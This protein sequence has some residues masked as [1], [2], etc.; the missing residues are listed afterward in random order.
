MAPN[1]GPHRLNEI[2]T[3]WTA[4]L[5]AHGDSTSV[6][7]AA[8]RALVERYGAAVHHYLLGILKDAHAADELLQEFLLALI[9]GDFHKAAPQRGRFRDYVKTVLAHLVSHY[10]RQD[11]RQPAL[12]ADHP[13]WQELADA[14]AA[15]LSLESS[16][17]QELM[18]RTWEV[19]AE[20]HPTLYQ[21]LWLRAEHPKL[22]S[23]ELAQRLGAQQGRNFTGDAVRQLLRRARSMFSDVLLDEVT[24]SLDCPERADLE[25]ELADLNLLSYCADALQRRF[26]SS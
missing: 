23:H 1:P 21:V 11:A 15:E 16:L 14:E 7:N 3:L 25:R 20:Q 19:L 17:R 5:A 24:A 18:T 12:A 9:R 10:R 4:L 6:R 2:S 8:Q 26:P 22:P 13:A